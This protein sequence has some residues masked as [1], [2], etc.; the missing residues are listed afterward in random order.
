MLASSILFILHF[1][2]EIM[3]N[4]VLIKKN[5]A[6]ILAL[7]LLLLI[8]TVN[9]QYLL[10]NRRFNYVVYFFCFTQSL[11]LWTDKMSSSVIAS[12]TCWILVT[13]VESII[14]SS[15]NREFEL[16]HPH[17]SS[18]GYCSSVTDFS[19][20]KKCNLSSHRLRIWQCDW[21]W[22]MVWMAVTMC[23]SQAEILGGT[24]WEKSTPHT[25]NIPIAIRLSSNDCLWNRTKPKANNVTRPIQVQTKS[26]DLYL[27]RH[28]CETNMVLYA[29]HIAKPDQYICLQIKHTIVLFSTFLRLL[30]TYKF[31]KERIILFRHICHF[32]NA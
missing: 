21:L 15:S 4:E 18:L 30:R 27:T 28:K 16:A 31:A 12:Q 22:P 20:W 32:P 14:L 3:P 5:I 6:I 10:A 7:T 29:I 26:I 19:S 25:A 11:S 17:C 24:T 9:F 23:Q 8:L 1:D 2:N 13:E